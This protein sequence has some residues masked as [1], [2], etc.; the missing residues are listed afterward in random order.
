M[1][2]VRYVP[3]GGTC[4]DGMLIVEETLSLSGLA[5]FFEEYVPVFLFDK[6]VLQNAG[7][8]ISK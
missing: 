2:R 4:G 3:D 5:G 6:N 1:P 7:G 8:K